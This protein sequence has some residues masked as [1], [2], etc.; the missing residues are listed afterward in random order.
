MW[1]LGATLPECHQYRQPWDVLNP[2]VAAGRRVVVAPALVLHVLLQQPT[3]PFCVAELVLGGHVVRLLWLLPSSGFLA[4]LLVPVFHYLHE[5]LRAAE[6]GAESL[7]VRPI[8]GLLLRVVWHHLFPSAGG[9]VRPKHV[10]PPKPAGGHDQH[11]GGGVVRVLLVLPPL[12]PFLTGLFFTFQT[13]PNQWS[14]SPSPLRY[15]L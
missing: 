1:G 4:R 5:A 12:G 14:L 15:S 10:D 7:C 2:S 8:H 6:S 3:P 9:V 13:V 11:C